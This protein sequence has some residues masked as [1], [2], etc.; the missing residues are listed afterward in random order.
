MSI[1]LCPHWVVAPTVPVGAAP[2]APA[3]WTSLSCSGSSMSWASK[4]FFAGWAIV[5]CH[6][7]SFFHLFSLFLFFSSRPG[8]SWLWHTSWA[9]LLRPSGSYVAPLPWDGA[10]QFVLSS[11]G[12]WYTSQL[13]MSQHGCYTMKLR[14][15]FKSTTHI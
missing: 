12:P 15:V 14:I 4:Q 9:L 1:K 2:P 5:G 11:K 6:P 7:S 3:C 10:A 13:C 8:S